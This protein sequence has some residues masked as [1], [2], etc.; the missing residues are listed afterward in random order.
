MNPIE[1]RS[2]VGKRSPIPDLNCDRRSKQTLEKP[3]AP[4]QTDHASLIPHI[5][6]TY[7]CLAAG[8]RQS[9]AVSR[10]TWQNRWELVLPLKVWHAR[11]YGFA[12]LIV[13][14]DH[15]RIDGKVRY[16]K[17][18]PAPGKWEQMMGWLIRRGA[19]VVW[20]IFISLEMALIL[21]LLSNQTWRVYRMYR[22]MKCKMHQYTYTIQM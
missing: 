8:Q 15:L 12:E 13:N 19:I 9:T 2:G 22:V 6:Y 10:A 14:A 11:P 1:L 21:Q 3:Q 7:T 17:F 18:I 5:H 20:W 4:Q 16:N